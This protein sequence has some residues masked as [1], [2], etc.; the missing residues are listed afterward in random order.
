[1]RAP[2]RK[3][4]MRRT[5]CMPEPG[6]DLAELAKRVSYVGSPEHKSSPSFA[7]APKLRGDATKCDPALDI[8]EITTWL[9]AGVVAGQIGAPW[10]GEFPRYVWQRTEARCY[11]ARLVNRGLGQYKGYALTD[12]EVPAWL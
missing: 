4:P 11:E 12:D 5:R 10:E 2:S 7:G 1:M 6:V 8:L 9:R 3:R